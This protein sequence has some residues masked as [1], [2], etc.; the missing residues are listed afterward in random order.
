MR[1]LIL[2]AA[3]LAGCGADGGGGGQ[4]AENPCDLP[5]ECPDEADVRLFENPN[6]GGVRCQR[7]DAVT[8]EWRNAFPSRVETDDGDGVKASAWTDNA[9]LSRSCVNGALGWEAVGAGSEDTLCLAFC[10]PEIVT[11]DVCDSISA[12]YPPCE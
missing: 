12:A 10:D 9:T 8:G 11:S 3:A 5:V 1:V 6:G 4:P 7:L 2:V